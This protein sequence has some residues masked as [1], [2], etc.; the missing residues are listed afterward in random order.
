MG[1]I[2]VNRAIA[3]HRTGARVCTITAV[4]P[5][6]RFGEIDLDD[7]GAVRTFNEKPQVEA[8]F[9]NGGFMVCNRRLFDY[10][11]ADEDVMLE[12][13]AL[14]ELAREGRLGMYQHDGFWQPMDTFQE[15]TLL[16]RLWDEDSA[17]WKVW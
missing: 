16:N 1:N 15:F 10:I 14:R 5:P 3:E 8:G 17:P 4:H 7:A 12:T 9:I 6:G 11:P 2:D 13:G